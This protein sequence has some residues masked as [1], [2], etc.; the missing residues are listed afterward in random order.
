[1]PSI[2]ER[3]LAMHNLSKFIKAKAKMIFYSMSPSIP[4][5]R[6]TDKS[7]IPGKQVQRLCV[8]STEWTSGQDWCPPMS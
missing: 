6:K 1:M 4:G 7:V 3:S 8:S 5:E 2:H